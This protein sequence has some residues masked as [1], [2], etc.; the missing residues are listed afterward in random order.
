V[1][2]HEPL[3]SLGARELAAALAPSIDHYLAV[4]TATQHQD[5]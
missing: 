2:P 4:A 3:S 1:Y 5:A